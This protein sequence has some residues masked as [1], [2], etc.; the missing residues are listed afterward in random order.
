MV[1]AALDQLSREGLSLGLDSVR[2]DDLIGV[3]D[4]PRA[5]AYRAWA[6]PDSDTGP[7]ER[8]HRAVIAE[9]LRDQPDSDNTTDDDQRV[10]ITATVDAIGDLL[11]QLPD[12]NT[13]TPA[14]RGHWLRQLHRAGSNENVEL[15][16][17][18]R[19]WRSYIA[20]AAGLM[21]RRDP[22][23]ELVAAWR[24]GEHKLIERYRD[25][26]IGMAAMFGF[27]L[28]YCYT[29]EQFNTATNALAEGL[30][31][32]APISDH[33]TGIRRNTA[34]DGTEQEWTLFAVCF[35]ALL[36]QFFE[37]DPDNPLT[38]IDHET[39]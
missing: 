35:E 37:P 19:L 25:L 30:T 9:L 34:L 14:E 4:A 28:R 6:D 26:Y 3:I 24:D 32:R 33:V 2:F 38:T 8:L 16:G 13:I 7:Q 1:R 12:L 31:I 22:P 27:R 5:S 11:Q 36:R 29:W 15:L 17:E 39:G 23:A 10:E 21:S 20:V 18:L